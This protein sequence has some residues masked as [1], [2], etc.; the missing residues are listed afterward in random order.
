MSLLHH[1]S[2]VIVEHTLHSTRASGGASVPPPLSTQGCSGDERRLADDLSSSVS[3]G[4]E[5]VKLTE[6]SETPEF[7]ASLG[8]KTEY[9]SGKW[10]EEVVPT[11]AP[12]LFQ[13]SNASGRFTVEEIFDFAQ[14]DLIQ[15]DVMIL[16]TYAQVFVWVGRDA[17]DV[18]KKEGLKTAKEY[19]ESDPSGRDLDSTQLLQ[20]KQGFEPPIFTCH[21]LGWNPNLWAQD[22]SYEAYLKEVKQGVTSVSDELAKYDPNKKFPYEQLKG[23][24]NCPEGVDPSNKE[25]HLTEEEFSKVFG[26]SIHDY[27]PLPQWK[28]NGLKKKVDLF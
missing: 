28:K 7:W 20:V 17:N 1:P 10:L 4:R 21:F 9:G 3:P 24:N 18:E 14:S 16:D 26:M 25:V 6:G 12:R 11:V 2:P 27:R 13:C 8:G 22:K 5:P 15:E 23:K 19:I